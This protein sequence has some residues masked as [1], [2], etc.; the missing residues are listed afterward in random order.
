[1]ERQQDKLLPMSE[2]FGRLDGPG[3]VITVRSLREVSV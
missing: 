3:A 1:M 2:S